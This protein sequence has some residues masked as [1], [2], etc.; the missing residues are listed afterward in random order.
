VLNFQN[1]IT[2]LEYKISGQSAQPS[3][4]QILVWFSR[5]TFWLFWIQ[6]WS[7]LGAQK[8][9]FGPYFGPFGT[10]GSLVCAFSIQ[11]LENLVQK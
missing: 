4:S 2:R 7:V 5:P 1:V 8:Q 9:G 3:A 10:S 6:L 11:N